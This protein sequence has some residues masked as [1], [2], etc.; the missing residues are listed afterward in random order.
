MEEQ[1]QWKYMWTCSEI[2]ILLYFP[3]NSVLLTY[4]EVLSKKSQPTFNMVTQFRY[5]VV[6]RL[7]LLKAFTQYDSTRPKQYELHE[8]DMCSV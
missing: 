2:P 1:K 7:T 3:F 8:D 5:N 4:K 6:N